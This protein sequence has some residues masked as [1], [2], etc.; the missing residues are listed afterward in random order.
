MSKAYGL[1]AVHMRRQRQLQEEQSGDDSEIPTDRA[2][3][4]K[5]GRSRVHGE[6]RT[7]VLR[8]LTFADHVLDDAVAPF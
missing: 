5:S 6:T 1:E 3:E 7:N 4:T 2:G 8:H